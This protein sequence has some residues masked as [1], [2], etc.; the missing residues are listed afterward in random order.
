MLD[1][2]NWSCYCQYMCTSAD[3]KNNLAQGNSRRSKGQ[4]N[5][6]AI[7]LASIRL[8]AMKGLGGV[9]LADLAA[10]VGISK[11]GLYAH[12]KTREELELA[13]V[14]EAVAILDREVLQPAMRARAGTERLRV[15]VRAFLS[16]LE[17]KVF[18]RGCFIAAAVVELETRPG[19]ACDLVAAALEQWIA[20]LRQCTQDAQAAGEIDP[21]A[22]VAQ[23]VFEI[24]AMMFAANFMFTM[25]DDLIH[26]AQAHAGVEN[27]LQRL[28]VSAEPKQATGT[29]DA[30]ASRQHSFS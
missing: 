27:V 22:D 23:T 29:H 7:V 24:Q 14:D 3:A 16:Y 15:L 4:G 28:A 25:T 18:P 11:S 6:A 10:E 30:A 26:L 1:Y 2:Y 12:F 13:T 17:R 9:S 21:N 8:A 5:R 20:L 19:P